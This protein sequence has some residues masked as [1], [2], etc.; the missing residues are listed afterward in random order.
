[1]ADEIDVDHGNPGSQLYLYALGGLSEHH[2]A[3]RQAL[4][5][6]DYNSI[7]PRRNTFDLIGTGST[8]DLGILGSGT[9]YSPRRR[10]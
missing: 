1:M 5:F 8:L 3:R 6:L 2:R 9:A 4:D 7:S 10:L